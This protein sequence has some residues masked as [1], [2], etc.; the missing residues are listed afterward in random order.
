MQEINSIKSTFF[1]WLMNLTALVT[2]FI[3]LL[4]FVAVVLAIIVSI[5]TIIINFTKIKNLFK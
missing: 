2:A 3:P 5:T 1:I 4:Q